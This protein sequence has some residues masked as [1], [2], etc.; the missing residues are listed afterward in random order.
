MIRYR[1]DVNDTVQE[2]EKK[3]LEKLD[4]LY[5]EYYT[6]TK[7][8]YHLKIRLNFYKKVNVNMII[9]KMALMV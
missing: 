2:L 8:Y 5:K 4:R 3:L 6:E 9:M 7:S 1:T